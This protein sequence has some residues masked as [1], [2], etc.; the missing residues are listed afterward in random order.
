V[1]TTETR[2]SGVRKTV[3]DMVGGG[4]REKKTGLGGCAC[5]KRKVK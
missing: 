1:L 5:S 4:V 2:G 3:R